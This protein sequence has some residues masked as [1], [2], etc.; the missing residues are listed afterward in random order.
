MSVSA[1]LNQITYSY[2]FCISCQYL[3]SV[4]PTTFSGHLLCPNLFVISSANLRSMHVCDVNMQKG[5]N[6]KAS[7][8]ARELLS[9]KNSNESTAHD[10]QCNYN[11]F[12]VL[13]RWC[14]S[15]FIPASSL[16]TNAFEYLAG[17][18]GPE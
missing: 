3:Y 13:T 18:L 9:L 16:G 11:Q 2:L 4:F 17:D 15:I 5:Q 7:S 12:I 8:Q 10:R 1:T 6:L 14:N